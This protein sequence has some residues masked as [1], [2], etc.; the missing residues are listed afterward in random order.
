MARTLDRMLGI[1]SAEAR[2]R[3]TS[4]QE[5]LGW[6]NA[7]AYLSQTYNALLRDTEVNEL[8]EQLI[9]LQEKLERIA[10]SGHQ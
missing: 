10:Q 7:V 4:S 2:K 9:E 6:V 3:S 5:R 8:K 1:A